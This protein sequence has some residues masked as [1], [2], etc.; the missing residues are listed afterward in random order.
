VR[1]DD[2]AAL[3]EKRLRELVDDLQQRPRPP[4][5]AWGAI[6]DAGLSRVDFPLGWGGLEVR[7]ELQRVVDDELARV[8]VPSNYQEHKG[9]I[10][11]VAPVLAA[12]GND[13]QKARYLRR[14]FT[15]EDKWCQLFSEPDAGSDLASLRSSVVRDGGEWVLN[16]HKVWTTM[17]H[18]AQRGLLLARSSDTARHR[19]I[20]CFI[21]DM[22][23]PGVDVRPLRQIT[24]DA[25]FN[26]VFF[27]DVRIPDDCR[28]GEVDEGWR[29]ALGT[30][31]VERFAVN[32]LLDNTVPAID[33]AR[34]VWDSL[35]H[36]Q[37][38]AARRARLAELIVESRVCDMTRRRG[39][40]LVERGAPGP[41]GSIV[42]LYSAELNKRVYEFCLDLRGPAGMLYDSYAMRQPA[43]WHEVGIPDGDVQR[44]F[45]R[46]RANSIEAGTSEIQRSTLAE[47][48]L[49]LPREPRA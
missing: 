10:A 19:G 46:S 43:T 27:T 13:E 38:S 11:I 25:E 24:G 28:V 44:A 48:V 12:F 15:A 36:E 39:A 31:M 35:P 32:Q 4:V 34:Q 14:V 41:E 7:G 49:G 20:T 5:E 16:G 2:E 40:A 3:V 42:K 9:G 29:V 21:L 47:R 1:Y 17:G 6:F 8:G 26:E 22:S 23:L 45:L 37:R 30:L 33:H 18:I